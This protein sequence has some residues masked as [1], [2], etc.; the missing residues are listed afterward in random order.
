MTAKSKTQPSTLQVF[1]ELDNL[2]SSRAELMVYHVVAPDSGPGLRFYDEEGIVA[3]GGIHAIEQTL[4]KESYWYKQLACIQEEGGSSSISPFEY[5]EPDP[6]GSDWKDG[7]RNPG[8]GGTELERHVFRTAFHAVDQMLQSWKQEEDGMIDAY[9][10][11]KLKVTPQRLR[12]IVKALQV[13]PAV[14][15]IVEICVLKYWYEASWAEPPLP[16]LVLAEY[17]L[18]IP[19]RFGWSVD[20]LIAVDVLPFATC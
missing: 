19:L 17:A 7:R 9:T 10:L 1:G 2:G 3:E 20:R 6:C 18:N 14:H 4:E 12:S 8:F 15:E 16:D 13:I 5:V 11:K